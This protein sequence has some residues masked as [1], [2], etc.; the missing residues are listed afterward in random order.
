MGRRVFFWV[1]GLSIQGGGG[2]FLSVCWGGLNTKGGFVEVGGRV[3]GGGGGGGRGT[4]WVKGGVG[5]GVDSLW[6]DVPVLR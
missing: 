2:W 1:G 5:C 6:W 4:G 3:V